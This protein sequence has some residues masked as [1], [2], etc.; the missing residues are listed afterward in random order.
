VYNN[1]ASNLGTYQELT[2]GAPY[3]LQT[4]VLQ[5]GFKT[6]QYLS[7]YYVEKASFLRLDNVTIDYT[8]P[9]RGQELRF[10]AG[11][12][13]AFTITGYSGV[14]PTAGVEGIDNNIYPR[15]RTFTGGLNVWF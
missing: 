11:V 1:V 13:N 10:F 9:W 7:D 8:F 14:D 5:T 15:S 4:S 2:R 12:Q 6:P 3:N